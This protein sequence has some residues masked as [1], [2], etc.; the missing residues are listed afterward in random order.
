MEKELYLVFKF[1][2]NGIPEFCG[3]YDDEDV[4]VKT[5]IYPNMCIY[6]AILNENLTDVPTRIWPRAWY[7]MLEGKP[8]QI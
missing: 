7:P 8:S 3:V 6:P 1:L 2:E 4:A 5:C